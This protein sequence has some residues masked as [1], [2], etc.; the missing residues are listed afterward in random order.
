MSNRN[1]TY[2]SY[3]SLL[4]SSQWQEK[5]KQILARDH[6]DCQ[7]CGEHSESNHVHHKFYL[8]KKMPWDYPDDA[9]IT[10]CQSCHYQEHKNV[11]IPWYEVVDGRIVKRN[12]I[13]EYSCGKCGGSGYLPEYNHV[14][15]GVCFSCGGFGSHKAEEFI[16]ELVIDHNSFGKDQANIEDLLEWN[17]EIKKSYTSMEFFPQENLERIIKARLNEAQRN[18]MFPNNVFKRKVK[19]QCENIE[20]DFQSNINVSIKENLNFKNDQIEEVDV[21]SSNEID[22]FWQ[23]SDLYRLIIFL[24]IICLIIAIAVFSN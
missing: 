11:N 15:S 23:R 20:N 2:R 8:R 13:W 6:C 14:Q 10:L 9:L 24:I 7:N 21:I 18:M 17:D 22:A 4:K 19:N 3:E 5:R 12:L 16:E 1:T